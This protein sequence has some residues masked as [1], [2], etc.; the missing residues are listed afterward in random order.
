MANAPQELVL[1][2]ASDMHVHLRQGILMEGVTPTIRDGGVDTVFVMPNLVPPIKTTD[3]ALAY[4]AQL[5]EQAPDVTFL[6]SLYLSPDLTPEEIH[7]AAK[8][9]VVGVKSY[10]RGVT[11]N[12]DSG[13]ESYTAY[14]PVF[15]AME[16]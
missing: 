10:P 12:S 15:K 14:Y 3:Q 8:S 9:G 7:K 16:D 6:M 2:Y 11:T 1:P 4:K 13:I 5:L